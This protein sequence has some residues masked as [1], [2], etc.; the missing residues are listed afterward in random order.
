MALEEKL[1]KYQEKIKQNP[2][3]NVIISITLSL[4][5]LIVVPIWR[6]NLYGI[7]NETVNATLENPYLSVLYK[8]LSFIDLAG[9]IGIATLYLTRKQTSAAERSNSIAM[10]SQKLD[11]LKIIVELLI[12]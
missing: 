4:L 10:E 8:I 11:L 6:V 9:F 12:S 2:L 1:K 7:S 3:T 5:L